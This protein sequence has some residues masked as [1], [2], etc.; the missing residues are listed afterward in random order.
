MADHF[1]H[2]DEPGK[3]LTPIWANVEAAGKHKF[4][5]V[6]IHQLNRILAEDR[7]CCTDIEGGGL[8]H[9]DPAGT[10]LKLDY[11]AQRQGPDGS[12]EPQ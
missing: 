9:T 11:T 4:V 6:T 2:T 12:K 5:K 8:H 10:L 3:V 1:N 7:P